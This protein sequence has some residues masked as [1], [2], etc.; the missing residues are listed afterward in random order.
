MINKYIH[1]YRNQKS[2]QVVISM[3][4][5]KYKY[6][7][8]LP[9]Y[10]PPLQSRELAQA[11]RFRLHQQVPEEARHLGDITSSYKGDCDIPPWLGG[12][13]KCEKSS[14]YFSYIN[15][16]EPP[17]KYILFKVFGPPGIVFDICAYGGL[18]DVRLVT[19][20]KSG[21]KYSLRDF[22]YQS[23]LYISKPRNTNQAFSVAIYAMP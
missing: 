14:P 13:P 11:E 4:K 19:D 22:R 18:G 7:D 23:N 6:H 15:K 10:N 17:E 1:Q 2:Q 16:A 3:Y 21:S 8:R 9:H 12:C 5:Y 20:V